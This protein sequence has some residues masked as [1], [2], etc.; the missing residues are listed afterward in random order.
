MRFFLIVFLFISASCLGQAQQPLLH[1]YGQVTDALSKEPLPGASI[2]SPA[3]KKGTQA[4]MEGHY[5]LKLPADTVT[6]VISFVGYEPRRLKLH[7]KQCD[8]AHNVSLKPVS[9]QEVVVEG[10]RTVNNRI[11][12]PILGLESIKASE[13]KE[14]PPLLGEA[15]PMRMLSLKP[16]ISNNGEGGNGFYIRGGGPDQNL[17]TMDD[18]VLYNPT[19]VAGIFS[20]F[21][22]DVINRVNLYKGGFPANFGGRLSSVVDVSLKE[23]D[24]ADYHVGGTLGAI[25]SHVTIEG[26][27]ERNKSSFLLA[28]RRTYFDLFT[29]YMNRQHSGDE[30]WRPIPA[31]YFQDY[32]LK[33]AFRPNANNHI[34]V[35]AYTGRDVFSYQN[36]GFKFRFAWGNTAGSVRWARFLRP[37][38]SNTISLLYTN[39]N[40]RI[41]NAADYFNFQVGSSVSDVTLKTDYLLEKNNGHLISFGGSLTQHR[42]IIARAS[43]SNADNTLNFAT[44]QTIDAL[45]GGVYFS[46]DITLSTKMQMQ[47]GLR[48]SGFSRQ[49]QSFMGFEPRLALRYSIDENLAV[50]MGYTRMYQYVHLVTNSGASL[51]A[52]I[53]YPAGSRIK[54]QISDQLGIGFSK[55]LGDKNWLF[56]H[57]LY[58]KRMTRQIDFKDGANLFLNERLDTVFVVGKGWAYGSEVYLEKVKGRTTGWIGYTLSWTWRQFDQINQGQPFHPRY[59]RRHDISVVVVHRF[60]KRWLA[61]A[62][63]VFGSGNAVTLPQGRFMYQDIQGTIP[64]PPGFLALPEIEKRNSYRMEPYHRGDVAVTYKLKPR[65]GESD[66]T[67]SIYNVYNRY[68]PYFIYFQTQTDKAQGGQGNITGFQAKQVSLFPIMPS[69]AYNFKF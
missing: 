53:W 61:S 55:G 17:I 68:N 1:A 4:D 28:G 37:D 9:G 19:H 64:N 22:N 65:R 48:I 5:S 7:I 31:Y 29:E 60:T 12:T 33:L 54:P 26:P 13:V 8:R 3:L 10:G 63:W 58:Y 20:L 39:Y 46:D 34:T 2:F 41:R 57:E 14:L 66:L 50:K 23:G 6:L 49:M 42:F 15:D 18:A 25:S 27:I 43:G 56:S 35:S 44:G 62:T 51:P 45:E 52:D 30:S 67:F 21:N 38:L 32:N 47:T 16:G 69:F 11:H 40:Y 59:D 36:P 24:Y